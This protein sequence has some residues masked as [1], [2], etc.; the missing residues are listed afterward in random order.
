MSRHRSRQRIVFRNAT[1]VV[2]LLALLGGVAF[3]GFVGFDRVSHRQDQPSAAQV[4]E[5]TQDP[6]FKAPPTVLVISDS[7]GA[8][9]DAAVQKSYPDELAKMM[10]WNLVFDVVGGR[11]YVETDM[12]RF[13]RGP[14]AP[15]IDSLKYDADN[16]R[17][18]YII[19]DVGRNDLGAKAPDDVIAAADNYFTQLRSYYPKAKIVVMI[20]AYISPLKGGTYDLIAGPMRQSAEKIGAYVLEPLAEDWYGGDLTP[21]QWTDGYHLNDA[22]AVFY[23]DKIARGLRRLGVT[24]SDGSE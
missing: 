11:G 19:V 12:S 2:V 5:P 22:G 8:Q 9:P 16:F 13:D 24:T 1:R 6:L 4:A 17:A 7:M 21:Y 18:D 20:P 23:A 3:A 14:V 10:G 15:A